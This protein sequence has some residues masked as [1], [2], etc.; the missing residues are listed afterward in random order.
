MNEPIA[1]PL[2]DTLWQDNLDLARAC[3]DDP[4]VAGLASGATDR[5]RFAWYVGQDAA[6]L[7]VFARAY[8][9]ALARSTDRE[10]LL[11]FTGLLQGVTTELRLHGAYAERWGIDLDAVEPG[12]ACLAY[13]DFLR[14]V[15]ALEPLP[16]V[17]AA[18]A[19]CMRLYAW[20]GRE[21]LGRLDPAS[22]YADW[23]HTY[24][25]PAFQAL[26]DRV[27]RLMALPGG[28]PAAMAHRYRRAMTLERD[29]FR[30][31]AAD[32]TA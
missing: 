8:A 6:F 7:E 14:A 25:D 13:T 9:L 18:R 28:D 26:A 12:P 21:L 24:A 3:L 20:L 15:A 2:A 32:P 30:A 29:F 1:M 23:V 17:M 5:R 16:Q 4:F 19:P 31:C 22:P 27:D 10:Q 11:I